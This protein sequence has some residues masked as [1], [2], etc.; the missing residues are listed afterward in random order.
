MFCGKCGTKMPEGARF[1]PECGAPAAEVSQNTVPMPPV[2]PAQPPVPPP[3]AGFSPQGS[4]QPDGGSKNLALGIGIAAL[5]LLLAGGGFAAW[6]FGWIG[7]DKPAE[8]AAV[9]TASQPAANKPQTEKQPQENAKP[10]GTAELIS[11]KKENPA[12]SVKGI[13]LGMTP[14]QVEQKLGKPDKILDSIKPLQ[15]GGNDFPEGWLYRYKNLVVRF[16]ANRVD[17]IVILYSSVRLTKSGLNCHSSMAE[18][19]KAYNLPEMPRV[20]NSPEESVSYPIGNGQ[21]ISFGA[22]MMYII[23]STY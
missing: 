20:P 22:D 12:E 11:V 23:L 10:A 13:Y 17:S 5:V 16:N 1:C 14:E 6:H 8:K 3:A 9:E 7:K 2:Q 21:A 4:A 15:V 19:Q 18:F